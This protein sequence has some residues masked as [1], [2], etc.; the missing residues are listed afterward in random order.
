[1]WGVSLPGDALLASLEALGAK[2]QMGRQWPAE[3]FTLWMLALWAK[4]LADEL[5]TKGLSAAEQLMTWG[6]TKDRDLESKEACRLL[7]EVFGNPCH[8]AIIAP[9]WRSAAVQAAA[10]TA[11]GDHHEPV[12]SLDPD[13]LAALAAALEDAGC[14]DTNI[15]THLREPGPHVRGCWALDLL[16]NG[17]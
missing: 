16:R 7:R 10:A 12:G 13:S 9:A 8:P 17:N 15:L 11:Y 5:E 14:D 3:C 2:I 4:A 1:M 6:G